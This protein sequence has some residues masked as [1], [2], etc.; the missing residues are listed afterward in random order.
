MWDKIANYI[1]KYRVLNLCIAAVLLVFLG[2]R[3]FNMKMG[4][5]MANTL[6][7][8]DTT[9]IVYRQFIEKYGQDGRSIFVGICDE[10]LFTLEHFQDYYDLNAQ[11]REIPGVTECLSVTRVYNLKKNDSIKKFELTQVV[12]QRPTTQA[13]VD[14][15]RDEIMSLAMASTSACVV[16]RCFTT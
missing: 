9:M 12:K 11:I 6:P 5:N 2:L 7:E 13:E 16:G 8:T 14:A 1:L 15:I 3:A 4:H 10:D